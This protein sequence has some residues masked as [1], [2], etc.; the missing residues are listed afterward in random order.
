MTDYQHT[1]ESY[2]MT[3][4]NLSEILFIKI[5]NVFKLNNKENSDMKEVVPVFSQ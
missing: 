2:Q 5:H 3:K 4:Q 1:K